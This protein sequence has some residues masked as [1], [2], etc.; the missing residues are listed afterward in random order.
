MPL[1][2]MIPRD[3][4]RQGVV[5][6]LLH[7]TAGN[8]YPMVIWARWSPRAQSISRSTPKAENHFWFVANRFSGHW[9]QNEMLF[10]SG[11]RIDASSICSD[12]G[13]APDDDVSIVTKSAS[14]HE[15]SNL[16]GAV[17]GVRG[18]AP[19][20]K[21]SVTFMHPPQH[22]HVDVSESVA[23]V[24]PVLSSSSCRDGTSSSFRH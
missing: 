12:L 18:E 20:S 10:G 4:L 5:E 24:A 1:A 9:E 13:D 11:D 16:I 15:L 6:T 14:R 3:P 2:R 7:G 8:E 19:R 22:G 23:S 17:T 21:V